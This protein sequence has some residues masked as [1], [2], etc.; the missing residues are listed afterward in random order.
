MIF[1][2]ALSYK[3]YNIRASQYKLIEFVIRL[4][5]VL[6]FHNEKHN[7]FLYID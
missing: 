2:I 3:I 6:N 7:I 1:D 4:S 5:Y